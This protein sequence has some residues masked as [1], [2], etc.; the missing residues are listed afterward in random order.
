MTI[1]SKNSSGK[2]HIMLNLTISTESAFSVEWDVRLASAEEPASDY[3]SKGYASFRQLIFDRLSLFLPAWKERNPSDLGI[4]LLEILAYISD[5]L[6]YFQDAVATESYIG[7]VRK[8]VSIRRL[9]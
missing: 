5:Y 3:L 1:D 8:R 2:M 4:V 7:T 6:S 9:P